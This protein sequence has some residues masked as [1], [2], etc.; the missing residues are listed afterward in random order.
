MI[1]VYVRI[2]W[3]NSVLFVY[4]RGFERAVQDRNTFVI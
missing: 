1:A 4:C 3:V 2:T